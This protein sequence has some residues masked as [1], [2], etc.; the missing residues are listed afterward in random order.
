MNEEGTSERQ[1]LKL[2][3]YM[4]LFLILLL[5]GGLLLLPLGGA[6]ALLWILLSAVGVV[7][8]INWHAGRFIYNCSNCGRPVKTFL[9]KDILSSQK[10]T[11]KSCLHCR[12]KNL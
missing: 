10:T 11:K 6:G 2:I 1:L 12:K 5:G 7:F 8:L 3:L 9:W 4:F